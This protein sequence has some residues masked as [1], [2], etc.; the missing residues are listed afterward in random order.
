MIQALEIKNSIFKQN[1]AG[2]ALDYDFTDS[3]TNPAA[4]HIFV[5]GGISNIIT[6]CEFVGGVGQSARFFPSLERSLL[7]SFFPPKYFESLTSSLIVF[8]YDPQVTQYFKTLTTSIQ[9]SNFIGNRHMQVVGLTDSSQYSGSLVR[10]T[11][12][13]KQNS[14]FLLLL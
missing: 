11:N 9:E 12:V 5:E 14:R 2:P 7:K 1:D 10:Y 8:H 3:D 13:N 6:N 4:S